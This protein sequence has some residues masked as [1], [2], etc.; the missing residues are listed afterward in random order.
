MAKTP[1]QITDELTA[2]LKGFG[3][4]VTPGEMAILLSKL[5]QFTDTVNGL[6]MNMFVKGD[7][8]GAAH[9]HLRDQI[10]AWDNLLAYYEGEV[11]KAPTG[12]AESIFETVTSP[13]LY[14]VCYGEP[15]CSQVLADQW[16]PSGFPITP[17]IQEPF[18]ILNAMGAAE[19]SALQNTFLKSVADTLAE[20]ASAAKKAVQQVAKSAFEALTPDFASWPAWAWALVGV[21]GFAA[22]F[23]LVRRA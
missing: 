12:N 22:V 23:A 7:I 8:E 11:A 21:L 4:A 6:E 18:I 13:L 5:R 9:T 1:Q 2:I 19:E 20:A 16:S 14:G 10:Q 15:S 3:V 17:R